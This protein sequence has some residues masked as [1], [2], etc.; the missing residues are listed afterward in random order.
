ML[1][2]CISFPRLPFEA[3]SLDEAALQV[4]TVEEKRAR[5]ILLASEAASEVNIVEGSDYATAL[6]LCANI[7][8]VERSPRAERS[9][10]DR[11]AAWAYQWSSFVTL[12][13]AD[14]D[15]LTEHSM[16]WLEIAASFTLFGGRAALLKRIESSLKQLGYEYRLGVACTL[17]GAALLA[18]AKKRVVAVTPEHLRRH[19]AEL[20][21]SLLALDATVLFEIKR[22]GIRTIRTFIDLPKDAL[23]RRFGPKVVDYL[24]RLL[25]RASDSRPMF[26]L[27][28]K[29]RARSELGAEVTNTEALL[30]PLKRML[31]ELQGYLRAVDC[32]LQ[33]FTLHLKHRQGATRIPIGFSESE[34]RVEQFFAIVCE[35]FE[36]VTLPAPVLEIGL[37]A[38]RFT[39]PAVQQTSIFADAQHAEQFHHVFDKIAARLGPDA[40]RHCKSI[41]DHRPEKAWRLC[42]AEDASKPVVPNA[43]RP[44]WLLAE[45]RAISTPLTIDGVAERIAG[46][47]WDGDD[48]ER[49]YFYIRSA[50]GAGCWVFRDLKTDQWFLH[51]L[52]G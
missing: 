7:K 43:P 35:R 33:R 8:A 24:D 6:A 19:L 27:P 28:K 52:C 34:R 17:E 3:L 29:Y 4:V 47:W 14:P 37:Q 42:D 18:R 30:F 51:G 16:L 38:D 25:G 11:L 1:W 22:A 50:D 26:Q 39:A 2:L 31:G 44:A 32:G 9:A 10:L 45:P 23:A 12:R 48:V 20:P 41:A 36:R 46:G 40:I 5:R 13:P 15:S 49:D 21:V